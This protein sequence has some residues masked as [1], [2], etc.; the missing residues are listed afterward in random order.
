M[1]PEYDFEW[2]GGKLTQVFPNVHHPKYDGVL[3]NAQGQPDGNDYSE[4]WNTNDVTQNPPGGRRP[5]GYSWY[6]LPGGRTADQWN[7][8]TKEIRN[9]QVTWWVNGIC[10]DQAQAATAQSQDAKDLFVVINLAMMDMD[11]CNHSPGFITNKDGSTPIPAEMQVRN[12]RI[13][14]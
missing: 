4:S 11:N 12:L 8:Y 2:D 10:L 7:T 14:A 1:P 5:G 6:N 9:G 13:W 3:S